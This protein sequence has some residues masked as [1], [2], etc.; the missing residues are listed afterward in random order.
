LIE[1]TILSNLVHNDKYTRNVLPFIKA[2]YFTDTTDRLV[3]NHI[4]QFVEKY[5][6]L[7]TKE[8]LYIELSNDKSLNEKQFESAR[9]LISQLD[10][11]ENTSEQ[12]LMDQSEAFC[13]SKAIY[14]AIH[15][16][17]AIY[18]KKLTEAAGRIPQLLQDAISV[19][20]DSTVGH[21]FVND[22]D[23]RYDSYSRVEKRI[24]TGLHFVDLITKGG[25]P[26][27]TFNVFIGPTGAGKTLCMCSVAANMLMLGYN[28]LYI[29]LEMAEDQIGKRIDQNLMDMT[30]E[31]LIF[32]GKDKY[33]KKM[34]EL[35]KT[36]TGRLKIKEYPTSSAHVGHFRHLL[37]DLKLKQ[38]F[39]P[40]VIFVD[41][42]NICAS[43]RMK[44][45]G[46]SYGYIKAIAE[47]LRGLCVE[48]NVCMITATQ[49]N[50]DSISASDFDL[51]NTSESIGLPMTADFMLAIIVTEELDE[52]NQIMFKQLKNRYSDPS[53]N[54]RFVVGVD[55]AKMKLYDVEQSAQEGLLD[56]PEADKP[57]MD[58]TRFGQED[59][60]RSNKQFGNNKFKGF[61]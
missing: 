26:R 22:S 42:V 16:V 39:I 51:R 48:E 3:F 8:A 20:F 2:E 17:I 47:E 23:Q 46:D 40:D 21:D 53:K 19:S 34:D 38:K 12:W 13:Q 33:K 44:L 31:D 4:T 43:N 10:P 7:P 56:G 49:S 6:A 11:T 29:T 1:H 52:L 14:N 30:E 27:K 35:K 54:R 32:L 60:E 41:Y 36:M 45:S 50:R 28:V 24:S 61:R 59:D 25:F 18:D 58:K 9:T 57:L 37:N 55:K 5:N 15:K